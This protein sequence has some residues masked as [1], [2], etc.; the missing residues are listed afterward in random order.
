MLEW[1]RCFAVRLTAAALLFG[2]LAWDGRIVDAEAGK[3][4]GEKGTVTFSAYAF[5]DDAPREPRIRLELSC[6]NEAVA[7]ASLKPDPKDAKTLPYRADEGERCEVRA[8]GWKGASIGAEVVLTIRHGDDVLG[9][10]IAH[11]GEGAAV[12]AEF[13][14]PAG[15]LDVEVT[16]EFTRQPLGTRLRVMEWNIWGGGREAGGAQNVDYLIEAIR[17]HDPDILFVVETYASGETI[18]NGLNAGLPEHRRYEAIKVSVDPAHLPDKDNLW[19]FSRYP[20][21]KRYPVI[22]HSGLMGDFHFGGA[23]VRLPDG[24]EVNVFDT[25]LY[26]EGG[27]W[28]SVNRTVGEATYGLPRTFTDAELLATDLVR[29]LQM[30]RKI[31]DY[32]LPTLLRGDDS[33]IIMAGDFNTLSNEDW[34]ARFADAPGHGGLALQWPVTQLIR[35]AGFTDTYRWANPDAGRHPGSTWSPYYGYGMAPGRIDY[36][37]TKGEQM[38]VLGSFTFDRRLPGHE[39]PGHPFYSDHAAVITDLMVRSAASW[40]AKPK[41]AELVVPA[42]G[43]KAVSTSQHAGYEAS[44]ATDGSLQTMWHSEWAPLA[45]L[46]QSITLDLGAAYDVVGLDYQT[47]TDFKPDGLITSYSVYASSD[48]AK[49]VKVADGNWERDYYRKSANFRAPA[50]RYIKLEATAGS[51]GVASAAEIAIRYAPR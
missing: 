11:P 51:G 22:K 31:V 41:P 7:E 40:P 3:G 8:S 5:G 9:R 25:W 2:G 18:A 35:E 21:V 30:T 27:A 17:H 33:P 13:H 36:I 6:G 50:A 20:M 44:K 19:I 12:S 49:F 34:S 28:G 1:I 23:K 48:G 39:I 43:V 37:W 42:S 32:N 26:H 10:R 29:R 14:A 47:R 45:P 38:R 15:A 24:Q 4:R 16:Q 46:P